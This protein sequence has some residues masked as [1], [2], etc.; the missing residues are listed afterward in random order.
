MKKRLSEIEK[1]N[2]KIVEE[3]KLKKKLTIFH[4]D[5]AIESFYGKPRNFPTR[6]F[7]FGY[8]SYILIKKREKEFFEKQIGNITENSQIYKI[9]PLKTDE[10]NETKKIYESSCSPINARKLGKKLQMQ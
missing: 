10:T 7:N 2:K 8:N 6:N 1:K 4:Q 3:P 9:K 5:E